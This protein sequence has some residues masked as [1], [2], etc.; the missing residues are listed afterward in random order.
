M[1][2]S[3]TAAPFYSPAGTASQCLCLH[4]PADTRCVP[5]VQIPANPNGREGRCPVLPGHEESSP[6][7]SR[8][9]AVWGWPR[10]GGLLRLCSDLKLRARR[11]G[12]NGEIWR[13][14]EKAPP[15]VPMGGFLLGSLGEA[16]SHRD[17]LGGAV[18]KHGPD[19]PCTERQRRPSG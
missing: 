10:V 3:T 12:S 15:G 2:F 7:C 4:I 17:A 16:W 18:G 8:P 14:K 13:P 5:V 9:Q 6:S 19:P 1:L 11:E